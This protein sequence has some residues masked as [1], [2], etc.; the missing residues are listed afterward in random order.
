M[1][2]L[3]V[4]N[5]STY[6]SPKIVENKTDNFVAYGDDNNYFQFLIDR[7][8]GSATNNAIINGMSEMIFGKGLDATDSARKPEAY[9]KM[10]TLF[11][12]DCV[13]R[14]ASDLKLMGNCA[15]QVIYSKDRKQYRKSRTYSS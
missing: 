11:H 7:Y 15:M 3:R 10:I 6:T 2:E 14:L 12:D 13:R 4:L 8:N 1:N 5:L 9:A